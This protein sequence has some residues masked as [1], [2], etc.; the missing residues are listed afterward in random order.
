MDLF[1]TIAE[2]HSYRGEFEKTPVPREALQ[3]IVDAGIRAPSACNAQTA[4]FVIVDDQAILAQI[5][6]L[7]DRPCLKT[8]AAMIVCVADHRAVYGNTSFG[9]EDCAA[10][11]E[12]MLLAITALGYASVWLD[13]MLRKDG[14]A[15]RIAAILGVPDNL[16]VR[17]LLPIGVPKEKGSQRERKAFNERAS[18]NRWSVQ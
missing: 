16:E 15:G 18:Y 7:G 1:K 14:I 2:R 9:A 3:K 8:A 13:G 10:A 6:G 17:V 12:N 4:S 5:A 11:V